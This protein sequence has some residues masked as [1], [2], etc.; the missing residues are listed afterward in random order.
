MKKTFV[1]MAA[2]LLTVTIR[3]QS[4]EKMSYQAVIRNS[5]N[6]LVTNTQVGMRI[7]IL[8]GLAT[9]TAVYAETHTPTTNANGLVSLEIG[10]GAV[11]NGDFAS[12]DWAN[13]TYFIK[14]E[15]DP[16]GGTNY[17]ITG[18]SQL[19]SVPYALHAK[20]AESIT[21]TL[22]E[23]D[24]VFTGSAASG[25]TNQDITS[26][27]NKLETEA[28]GSV[29]NEIQLLNISNDTI[30]LTNGGFAKLP[31]GFDG[32]YS[33]LTG[34]PANV[35][36]FAN[37]VGYLTSFTEADS[38]VTN[39]IQIL[40]IRN[41]TIYL[42]EGGFVKIP[43]VNWLLT[44]NAGTADGINFI[45]T[46]DN[47]PL[48]FK[49]NNQR[50]GRID[51][52]GVTSYGYQAANSNTGARNT[53]I[54]YHALFNNTSSG[55]NTAV[56]YQAMESN[57]GSGL[58]TAVGSHALMKNTTG[59]WNT[60]IGASSLTSN[61]TGTMNT[62]VGG[63]ALG[64]NTDG[65]GNIAV[66]GGSLNYFKSGTHNTSVG[67]QCMLNATS[68]SHNTAIGYQAGG[69]SVSGSYNVFVGSRAGYNETGSNKLYIANSETNPPLIYGDFSA[70]LVGIGTATPEAALDVN[71]DLKVSGNFY[72]PGTVVQTIIK[73]S[74]NTSYLDVTT[75]T[76]ADTGYRISITPK[77]DN[78]IFLIEYSFSINTYMSMHNTIFQM[79]LIRDIGGSE[80]LVGVGP[81]NGTRNRTTYV[82]RPNNGTDTNDMQNVY[83][84]A[85]DSGLTVGTTY[86]YG[87][88][89]RREN[90]GN[91]TCYFN[92]SFG[93]SSIY[94]FSGIMTMK[95]TEIAQ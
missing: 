28:D 12:I 22:S 30:Y 36:A 29:T 79:Q 85:K 73:T 37:D 54:G 8:K 32:Q 62:A 47:V 16:S 43:P 38:S 6:A 58:N 33:S 77:Y 68:G 35:S 9:G 87:F 76:E 52:G 4:P 26:W 61:T 56:G 92:Y 15:T 44:G 3:A 48:N 18:T 2:V 89:Y 91:G 50:S 25:I 34:A 78:S 20:T 94:G 74:E 71:G 69:N 66:G 90:N 49:V 23:A 80:T 21:G 27:N 93:D 17:T 60:A 84:V 7:S 10:S 95:V 39:E 42:S 24:P 75:F 31:A 53:G 1:T 88:K 63:G 40:S 57:T 14:T 65:G 13:D 5:S 86:T 70:G 46:T 55:D 19:L 67:F 59:E 83:L 64:S 82:S 51:P 45:G 72:A 41:D 11:E 81:E